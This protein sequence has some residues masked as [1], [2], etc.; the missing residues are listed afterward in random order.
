MISLPHPRRT[1]VLHGALRRGHP[2]SKLHL[3]PPR[4][5]W[6]AIL[7]QHR[8]RGGSSRTSGH[9]PPVG[10]GQEA[11]RAS[12]LSQSCEESFLALWWQLVLAISKVFF[13]SARH[14]C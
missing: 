12:R 11:K 14:P 8:K 9:R 3:A 13:W 6:Q 2:R 5:S 10:G 1:K 4:F 7:M